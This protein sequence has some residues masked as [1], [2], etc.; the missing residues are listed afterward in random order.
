MVGIVLG[1]VH[2]NFRGALSSC[3]LFRGARHLLCSVAERGCVFSNLGNTHYTF[4]A[5]LGI[6]LV[7]LVLIVFYEY[8]ETRCYTDFSV[9]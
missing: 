7:G 2:K 9:V 5:E 3:L 1:R 6:A 8:E 4:A